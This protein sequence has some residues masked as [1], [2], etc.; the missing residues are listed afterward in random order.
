M[1]HFLANRGPGKSGP[2]RL[3]PATWAPVIAFPKKI[4]KEL[5]SDKHIVPQELKALY[6]HNW[7][8]SY[9]SASSVKIII[10]RIQAADHN[11]EDCWSK[12]IYE[13]IKSVQLI[14]HRNTPRSIS[15]VCNI[16]DPDP[17]M[18]RPASRR[19]VHLIF[20]I[21]HRNHMME[22]F[23]VTTGGSVVFKTDP[24]KLP[25]AKCLMI[26]HYLHMKQSLAIE[27]WT[28]DQHCELKWCVSFSNIE[29]GGRLKT[30]NTCSLDRCSIDC[31]NWSLVELCWAQWVRLRRHQ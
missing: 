24:S 5:R 20:S 19:L 1:F 3:G 2:G 13:Q 17:I 8:V 27:Q 16:V 18:T 30:G 6:C 15:I 31:S 4:M 9:A 11:E 28:I 7:K 14:A 23:A 21:G 10:M 25:Y 26:L 29:D 12:R 22:R